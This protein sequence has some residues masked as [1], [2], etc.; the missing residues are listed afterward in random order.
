MKIQEIQDNIVQDF[1]FFD[2]W[3]GR[4]QHLIDLGKDL[5]ELSEEEKKE[6]W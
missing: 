1:S 4:Y 3:E 2:D 5:A 6:I